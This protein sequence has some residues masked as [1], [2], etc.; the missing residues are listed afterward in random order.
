VVQE[1]QAQIVLR[2]DLA[3]QLGVSSR[4][5]ENWEKDGRIA[6]SRRIGPRMKGWLAS[7]VA[8]FLAKGAAR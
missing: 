2:R 8:E 4:T 7:E 5:L 1:I 3:R 6:P